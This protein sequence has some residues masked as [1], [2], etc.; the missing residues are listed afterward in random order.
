[1]LAIVNP[2]GIIPIWTELTG[3]TETKVR[4]RIAGLAVGTAVLVWLIFLVGSQYLLQFFSIDI[5]VFKV[6]GGILLFYTALSMIE[7]KATQ[8][9]ERSEQGDTNFQLA[10][11]RFRK[12]IVPLVVPMLAGPGSI[13]TVILYGSRAQGIMDYA[14]LSVVALGAGFL[15]FA[16]FAYSYYLEKRTDSLIFTVFTRIF[17]IIVA[18]I[19]MQFILEGLGEVFPNWLEGQSTFDNPDSNGAS[20]SSQK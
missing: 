9:E 16:T 17:G 3:D 7:G 4:T 11:A 6:A 15:L 2:I 13:T 12:V 5:P 10:K 14:S 8:L 1:M 19:A 18:A 20:G